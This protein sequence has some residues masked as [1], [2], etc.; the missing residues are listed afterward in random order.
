MRK[1]SL[2]TVCVDH[3]RRN[4]KRDNRTIPYLVLLKIKFSFQSTQLSNTIW[5]I[6]L[7]RNSMKIT[8]SFLEMINNNLQRRTWIY[9]MLCKLSTI[10]SYL[11]HHSQNWNNNLFKKEKL[12]LFSCAYRKQ[13]LMNSMTIV[14]LKVFKMMSSKLKI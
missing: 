10:V 14:I 1:I 5:K 4:S 6:T 3:K 13:L 2:W 9:P 11:W 12:L 7:I 8:I